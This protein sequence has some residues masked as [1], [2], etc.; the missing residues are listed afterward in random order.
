MAKKTVKEPAKVECT[1]YRTDRLEFEF[2]A[3]GYLINAWTI[4]T[5]DG[6]QLCINNTYVDDNDMWCLR[7]DDCFVFTEAE[8]D[9]F[10]KQIKTKLFNRK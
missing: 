4:E 8:F 6:E 3:C 1:V 10:V 5:D 7:A 2:N 9:E